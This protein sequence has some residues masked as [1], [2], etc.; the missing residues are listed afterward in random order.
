[1][2]DELRI[3]R[4]IALEARQGLRVA[5]CALPSE[6]YEEDTDDHQE[7]P[8]GDRPRQPQEGPE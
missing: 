6:A 8:Q 1:M 7:E 3:R 4:K 5:L 2:E